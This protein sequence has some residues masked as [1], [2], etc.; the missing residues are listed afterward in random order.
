MI[1]VY[2]HPATAAPEEMKDIRIEQGISG[3]TPGLLHRNLQ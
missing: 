2:I 1:R 3:P